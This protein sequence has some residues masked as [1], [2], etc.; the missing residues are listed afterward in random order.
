MRAFRAFY[1]WLSDSLDK[2]NPARNLKTPKVDEPPVRSVS[3]DDHRAMLATCDSKRTGRRD[4]AILTILWSTGMRR[5]EIARMERTHVDLAERTIVIPKSKNGRARTV[6]L[7]DDAVRALQRYLRGRHLHP[8]ARSPYLWL[9]KKGP[10]TADG[11]YQ[12]IVRRA[13]QA[14]VDVRTHQYRRALAE[15]WVAAGGAESLLRAYAGWRSPA[16]GREV[17]ASERR[18]ARGRRTPPAAVRSFR[19]ATTRCATPA[20]LLQQSAGASAEP[21]RPQRRPC[22]AAHQAGLVHAEGVAALMDAVDAFA[23]LS[24]AERTLACGIW[25]KASRF[26]GSARDAL[27]EFGQSQGWSD[28]V[29]NDVLRLIQRD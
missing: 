6:G 19:R 11:I 17:G 3:L 5:S 13:A 23:I 8:H 2:P 29:L 18:E 28:E 22:D 7:D 24:E 25:T 10:L 21:G 14:R 1:G 27:V 20:E 9:A 26:A 15:R 4:A 12:M 16:H